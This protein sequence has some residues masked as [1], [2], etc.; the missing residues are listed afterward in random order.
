MA[1]YETLIVVAV[2]I[3]HINIHDVSRYGT[4]AVV[5]VGVTTSA[6]R[7]SLRSFSSARSDRISH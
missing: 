7:I 4:Y 1:S 5:S 3:R 6:R 2:N